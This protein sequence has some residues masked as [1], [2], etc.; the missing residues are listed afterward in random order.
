MSWTILSRMELQEWSKISRTTSTRLD[1]SKTSSS[2]SQQELNRELSLE[3]RLRD[4]S[5]L[6]T[7]QANSSMKE[8]SLNRQERNLWASHQQ[9]AWRRKIWR[10]Q[11]VVEVVL[12]QLLLPL[13]IITNMEVLEAK[14]LTEWDTTMLSNMEL[15]VSMIHT[16][17]QIASQLMLKFQRRRKRKTTQ[18]SMIIVAQIQVTLMLTVMTQKFKEKRRRNKREKQRKRLK[19]RRLRLNYLKHKVK[20]LSHLKAY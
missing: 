17:R 20:L 11:E 13:V 10:P 12:H 16:Q 2:K 1:N 8:S 9:V 19:K 6:S 18:L 7:S 4:L 14:I 5:N 3:I 15:R